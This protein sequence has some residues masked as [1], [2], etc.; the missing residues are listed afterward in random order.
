MNFNRESKT[1]VIPFVTTYFPNADNN[2]S[3]KIVK[4]NLK[5]LENAE[6]KTI[7][8][9]Q[10]LFYY[11]GNQKIYIGNESLLHSE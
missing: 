11:L 10:T 3:I 1:N 7:L 5:Y 9:I 2:T 6:L 8:E 4:Q